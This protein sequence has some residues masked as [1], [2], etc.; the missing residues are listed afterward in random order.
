[1]SSL[2]KLI[3][4]SH[5]SLP[6]FSFLPH[7]HLRDSMIWSVMDLADNHQPCLPVSWLEF[8]ATMEVFLN[9]EPGFLEGLT[10]IWKWDLEFAVSLFMQK[11]SS[12]SCFSSARLSSLLCTFQF[13]L[14]DLQCLHRPC[15][16]F[17]LANPRPPSL[18]HASLTASLKPARLS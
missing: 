16:H 6:A 8:G 14:T 2:F 12:W 1:M 17:P 18:Q 15:E 4:N 3:L 9:W 10:A 5:L 11:Y 13:L 7:V